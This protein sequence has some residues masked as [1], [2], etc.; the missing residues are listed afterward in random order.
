[1]PA[2]DGQQLREQGNAAFKARERVHGSVHTGVVTVFA[3]GAD[4][5]ARRQE[6]RYEDAVGLYERAL[7]T[8]PSDAGLLCNCAATHLRLGDH[9]QVRRA[10]ALKSYG[11]T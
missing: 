7:K 6:G 3:R 11:D 8:L 2:I 4:A 5:P 1:M 9:R 10:G